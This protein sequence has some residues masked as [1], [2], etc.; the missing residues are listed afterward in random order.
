MGCHGIPPDAADSHM[1]S[2]G[3]PCGDPRPPTNSRVGP[4][5]T[6]PQL[7]F[8]GMSRGPMWTHAQATAET[9]DTLAILRDAVGCSHGVPQG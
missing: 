2:R 4:G 1:E 9:L 3:F 7:R 5:G 6:I 8:R